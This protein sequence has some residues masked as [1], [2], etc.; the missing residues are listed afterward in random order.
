MGRNSTKSCSEIDPIAFVPN[1]DMYELDK[2]PY[3]WN[4]D[5]VAIGER[6]TISGWCLP[7]GGRLGNTEIVINGHSFDPVRSSPRGIFAELYPWHPNAALAGFT[8]SVSHD[9]FD[10]RRFDEISISCVERSSRGEEAGYT[11]DLLIKDL[12]YKIPPSDV[13]ARIGV[14]N[15]FHYAMF[16]RAIFRGF[17]KTL[18][19]NCKKSFSDFPAVIDWGCGSARIARHVIGALKSNSKF[20]GFDIDT[21]AIAWANENVGPYFRV[22]SARPPL[23]Q[24]TA[25]VDLVYAYSVFTHLA[26]ENLASWLDEMARILKPGGI[27]MFTVL[28][29]RAM[30]ALLPGLPRHTLETWRATGIFDSLKNAQLDAINVP[31]DYYRN[32]WLTR[33][34][35]R[36]IFSA[37]FEIIDFVG[38]FH[39]YQD[40]VVVRRL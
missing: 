5:S 34:Y 28:S 35:I 17:E 6:T 36:K 29:D 3:L 11:L 40:L 22:S 24:A 21:V 1:A 31:S 14:E 13:A 30:I 26:A 4:V 9:V 18:R 7:H 33:D 20:L 15:I 10:V 23:D 27:G 19:K 32:V 8:L 25:S 12:E 39:F 2:A 37:H 38:S 16:G